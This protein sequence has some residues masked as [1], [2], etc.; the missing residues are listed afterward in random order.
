[1]PPDNQRA[2]VLLRELDDPN[3]LESPRGYDHAAVRARF[4]ELTIRLNRTFDCTCEVDH[5]VQ[6]ASYHGTITIPDSATASSDHIT[7]I[8]SNFGNLIAVT[9]GNVGDYD[10][11]E[12]GE[13]LHPDD[14]DQ[15]DHMLEDLGYV[16]ISQ[17]LLETAYDGTNESLKAAYPGREP[18]WWIRYF[19]YT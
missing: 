14:K 2:W 3:Y 18:T 7:V 9:L 12:E 5:D 17:H 11:D 10:A 16:A 15:I 6:D 13:L 1:M 19:D 4:N 8:V